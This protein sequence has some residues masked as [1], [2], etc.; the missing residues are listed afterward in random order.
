MPD[1]GRLDFL[2]LPEE[3][4]ALRVETGVRQG[5]EISVFYDP[6]IAKVI[7]HGTD[8]ADALGKLHTALRD[9]N[10]VGVRT[11]I[12]LIRKIIAMDEYREK[13]VDTSFIAAHSERLFERLPDS[14]EDIALAAVVNFIS[15]QRKGGNQCSRAGHDGNRS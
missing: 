1:V 4:E 11:N 9:F 3:S 2:R 7:A 6:M 5:D 13:A 10:V 15:L 8:R 12:P 14:S